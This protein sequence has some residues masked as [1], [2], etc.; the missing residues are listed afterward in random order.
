MQCSSSAEAIEEK[1][2]DGFLMGRW[3][4]GTG[5]RDQDKVRGDED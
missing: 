1:A 4:A 5:R 2:T 3:D